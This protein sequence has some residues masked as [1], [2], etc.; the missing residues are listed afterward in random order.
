MRA[1]RYLIATQKETPSDAEI[2]SHQLMLRAGMI[3]KLAAGLYTWLPMGLRTLRKVERIVREEMDKSGAQEVLMPAVQP[4]ELWQESGRWEQYGGELLRMNDRHGRDFCF[5]PTHEEVITDLIRNELNSYKELP[6]NFY[7]IQT[8]FRDER[9]PRFGVM[10]AREFIMKD[11][12]SFHV[13][14]ESLDETYQIMHRTYCAIFDRLGLDYRPVQADSGA[15]GGSASHEFH[16]LA[17][18]G[19]DDIVFSTQSDYAANIEKAEAVAPSGERA[20]PTEELKEIATPDQRT[21]EAISQ[22]LNID[23]IRTVKTLLVKAEAKEEEDTSNAGLVALILR[24]DHSLNEIKAENLEGVADPLTMAT[25]EEIE[26]AVGCKAGS[27]GP[28]NLN[29]PVIVDRSAAQ[30]AD[31]VCGANKEGYHLTGVNWERDLPL[32]RVEDIRNVVE[33]DPSP[34][35]KGTLEIRRG[36]EVGHIFKLGNKYSTAMNATVLDENG[37]TVIMDMGCY[38]IGV[39]RIVAASIE[40]NHD[41]KGIIWPDAIAPFQVAIVTLNAHKTPVVAEAG[42]KLYE[43]LKQAGYDVLLDD[44]K[45]RPG[46]KFADME[47]IGIPHRFVISDRGLAAGTLEYKGRRDEDK[48]DIA[49]E[50]ALPFLI[51]ASPRKG[52]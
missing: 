35:G 31:F 29:V 25:D 20:L 22:F 10:R 52:L 12:Y 23:A 8:K 1:S 41:D 5:G 6:A 28:V 26:A 14:A 17:S 45:E 48:Q 51:N 32:G 47:L 44:R 21:I 33:G 30:L 11:A 24:G 9:R 36:I 43:Q 4:A 19:E 13:N 18:S 49:I 27:I 50:E 7:Q 38:G 34:D 3:R 37:K 46:V 42:E 16:V 2:I 39:S 40:Q 15:I